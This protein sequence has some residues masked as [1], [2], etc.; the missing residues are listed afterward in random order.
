MSAEDAELLRRYCPVLCF[1]SAE[2]VRVITF[3]GCW[4]QPRSSNALLRTVLST[5]RPALS[6]LMYSRCVCI[7][8]WQLTLW[9]LPCALPLWS[10]RVSSILT[11]VAP[12]SLTAYVHQSSLR[13]TRDGSLLQPSARLHLH[14]YFHY[15]RLLALS[16]MRLLATCN[17]GVAR[18]CVQRSQSTFAFT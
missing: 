1:D 11:Q 17:A 16:S 10:S 13:R 4:C 8:A 15:I 7:C 6:A 18:I 9:Q 3:Q 14:R 5:P 12:M 2:P